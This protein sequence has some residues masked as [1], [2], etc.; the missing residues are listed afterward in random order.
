MTGTRRALVEAG[1]KVK[2]ERTMRVI[3][4][5]YNSDGDRVL[6]WEGSFAGREVLVA[7]GERAPPGTATIRRVEYHDI[8][9]VTDP[10]VRKTFKTLAE[11]KKWLVEYKASNGRPKAKRPPRPI[12]TTT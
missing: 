8:H 2:G 1:L 4:Q 11:M 9:P 12:R 5:Y 7:P 10:E 6:E 3:W